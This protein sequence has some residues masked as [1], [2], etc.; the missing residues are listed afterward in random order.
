MAFI[1]QTHIDDGEVLRM[2]TARITAALEGTSDNIKVLEFGEPL[3]NELSIAVAVAGMMIDPDQTRRAPL[4]ADLSN[5]TVTLEC[6]IDPE[7]VK[8]CIYKLPWL[9]SKVAVAFGNQSVRSVADGA[10]LGTGH[11]IK[12]GRMKRTYMGAPPE[13][14]RNL[15]ICRL[16]CP[17]RFKRE[18]GSGIVAR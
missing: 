4:D 5:G 13:E 18:S 12:F 6:V 15:K 3:P 11:E 2:I 8:D 17:A 1:A 14:P 10:A 9:A 7:I 16:E